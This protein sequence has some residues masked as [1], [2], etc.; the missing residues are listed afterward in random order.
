[1]T[2]IAAAWSRLHRLCARWLLGQKIRIEGTLPDDARAAKDGSFR[3]GF[4]TEETLEKVH[5]LARIAK[6]RGQTLAQMALAWCPRDPRVTSVLI[7]ASSV[8]QLEEN[9]AALEN[10]AFTQE[11]LDEIDRFATDAG[12]NIWRASSEAGGE[13]HDDRATAAE[14]DAR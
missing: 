9:V 10:L 3:R 1:M 14:R 2:S 5:G 6:R 4:L 7:G 8:R 11:E 12:I 13:P